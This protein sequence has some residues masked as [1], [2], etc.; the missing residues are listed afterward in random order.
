MA[1]VL[2]RRANKLGRRANK[3]N[4]MR[5]FNVLAIWKTS[6]RMCLSSIMTPQR[7]WAGGS[8]GASWH[9]SPGEH[10]DAQGGE[11]R[12]RYAGADGSYP[13]RSHFPRSAFRPFFSWKPLQGPSGTQ[14]AWREP[15]ERN[16]LP[17]RL[18][19]FL[20][21]QR[22]RVREGTLEQARRVTGKSL[23]GYVL[24][25]ILIYLIQKRLVFF[26]TWEVAT[27][28]HDT[29]NKSESGNL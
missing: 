13:A 28:P 20:G 19:P 2:G 14:S 25:I 8:L 9:Q 18:R 1:A 6:I 22:W 15:K 12:R 23:Q 17:N 5:N 11:T 24:T 27:P 4:F 16:D 10:R 7:F 3:R 26:P 29:R 21:P